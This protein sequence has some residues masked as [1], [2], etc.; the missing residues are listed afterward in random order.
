[1]PRKGIGTRK[2]GDCA[3]HI[4]QTQRSTRQND[5]ALQVAGVYFERQ[6]DL[7]EQ[8]ADLLIG[9][10]VRVGDVARSGGGSRQITFAIAIRIWLCGQGR[11]AQEA[12]NPDR[13]EYGRHGNRGA[14]DGSVGLVICF[15]HAEIDR[16][17]DHTG[18]NS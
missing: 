6:H 1:M 17:R 9:F 12:V 7:I 3:I 15:G 11:V 2:G 5:P 13:R 10:V 18:Q 16:N 14:P 8:F 4:P